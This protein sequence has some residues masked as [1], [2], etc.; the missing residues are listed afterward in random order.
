M[1]AESLVKVLR[2]AR[3]R[4]WFNVF[5]QALPVHDGIRMKS[6]SMTGVRSYAGYIRGTDGTM[7]VFSVIVNNYSGS[8]AVTARR[9]REL[10]ALMS[11]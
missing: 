8:G 1:T 3:K 7:R 2:D 6:G 9:L 4:P 10:I 5:E 11:R